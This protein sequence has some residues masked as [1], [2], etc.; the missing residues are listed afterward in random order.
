MVKAFVGLLLGLI[1]AVPVGSYVTARFV[2][3]PRVVANH[4]RFLKIKGQIEEDLHK[5]EKAWPFSAPTFQQDAGPT[6]QPYV[7]VEGAPDATPRATEITALFAK[8]PYWKDAVGEKKKLLAA[9]AAEPSL[10]T[11]WVASLLDFDYWSVDGQAA[12]PNY[13][14]LRLWLTLYALRAEGKNRGEKLIEIFKRGALLAHSTGTLVGHIHS[15]LILEDAIDLAGAPFDKSAI[16]AYR[17]LGWAS[18][19]LL[20][21]S[22]FGYEHEDLSAILRPEVAGCAGAYEL[23]PAVQSVKDALDPK[24]FLE[25]DMSSNMSAIRSHLNR[26]YDECHLLALK[27]KIVVSADGEG[28]P[29]LRR[30]PALG[31]MAVSLPNTLKIYERR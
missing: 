30:F 8:Y 14:D 26:L 3:W 19:A 21:E 5:A 1:L 17:R 7:S 24:V 2:F 15:T 23:T 29:Y 25:W 20:K 13:K 11:R 6:L 28:T 16:E 31:I 9:A 27:E 12:L 18:V 4:H 22:W 10:D